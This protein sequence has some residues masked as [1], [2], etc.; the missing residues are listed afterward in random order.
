M[1][2]IVVFLLALAMIMSMFLVGCGKADETDKTDDPVTPPASSE[3]DN[4]EDA[5]DGNDD[6][7]EEPLEDVSLR[8]IWW[9]SQERADLTTEA[10]DIYTEQN[11]NITFET[12]FASWDDYWDKVATY[13]AANS[14]PDIFQHDYAKISEFVDTDLLADLTPYVDSGILDLSDVDDNFVSGGRFDDGLYAISLGTNTIGMLFDPDAI[15]DAGL[16]VPK[17]GWT[18]TDYEEMATTIFEETGI[19]TDIPFATDPK[20]MF[21]YN[22]RSMGIHYLVMMEKA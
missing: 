1:K 11:S 18:W 8:V 14:L 4:E 15:T 9:G 10:L 13:A 3:T 16:E 19:L 20:F 21:E 22:A 17:P 5:D 7:A 2:K 6:L 12:E